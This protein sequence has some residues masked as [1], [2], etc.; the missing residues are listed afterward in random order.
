MSSGRHMKPVYVDGREYC[1][2]MMARLELQATSG[3]AYRRF[4]IALRTGGTFRGHTISFHPTKG[5]EA[6]KEAKQREQGAALLRGHETHRI[7][8]YVDSR[9]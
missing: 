2:M 8:H 5:E 1:S 7:G 3:N 6:G 4:T 9:W